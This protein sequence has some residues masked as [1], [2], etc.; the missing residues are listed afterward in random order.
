MAPTM[1]TGF[2]QLTVASRKK[3]VSSRTSV[4]WV[5]TA[6]DIVGSSQTYWLICFAIVISR[7][8]VTSSDPTFA[9][10][11]PAT[12]EIFKISGTA[13]I[14]VRIPTTPAV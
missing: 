5:T 13:F 10:W 9:D 4:P 14:R 2:P 12:F 6:P 7:S 8:D 3:A 11:I 1:M